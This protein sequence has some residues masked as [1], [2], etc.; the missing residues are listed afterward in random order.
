MRLCQSKY[1]RYRPREYDSED[2]PWDPVT[3]AAAALLGTIG[4][5]MM[6]VADFPIEFLRAVKITPNSQSS[7]TSKGQASFGSVAEPPSANSYHGRSSATSVNLSHS[8]ESLASPSTT[9]IANPDDPGIT[10][11]PTNISK[12]EDRDSA[13]LSPRLTSDHRSM[14]GKAIGRP[15]PRS[16]SPSGNSRSQSPSYFGRR[17]QIGAEGNRMTLDSALRTGK[18]VGRIVGVGLKSPLDFTMSLA[19]GFHNAPKL[20][21]DESVRQT[22]KVTGIQSGL[23]VATQVRDVLNLS[24]PLTHNRRNLVMGYMMAYQA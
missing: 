19:R 7:H 6:G 10:A 16:R 22:N 13:A 15:S 24:Y 23:R 8:A 2:G 1:Y 11:E 20:Y 12:D 5:L 4:S 14:L 9:D 17:S 21:G 18:G 3:G